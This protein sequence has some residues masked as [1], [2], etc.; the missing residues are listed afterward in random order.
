VCYNI[1]H[2]EPNQPEGSAKVGRHTFSARLTKK[3]CPILKVLKKVDRFKWDDKCEEAFNEI[4]TAI[5]SM[6]ILEKT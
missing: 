1:I 2:E 5:S 3:I 6:P 4:K